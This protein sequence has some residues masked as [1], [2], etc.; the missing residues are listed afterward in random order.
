MTQKAY[1]IEVASS[2]AKL[3]AGETD[4]WQSGKVESAEQINSLAAASMQV[5]T[6]AITICI[7]GI[8][9]RRSIS[10]LYDFARIIKNNENME[11]PII[12]DAGFADCCKKVIINKK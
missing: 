2:D 4:L 7:W 8:S 6:K 9:T 10:F 11:G 3:L 1:Q 12:I 5:A